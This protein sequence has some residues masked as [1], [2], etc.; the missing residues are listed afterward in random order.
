MSDIFDPLHQ[1]H[2]QLFLR[3]VLGGLLVLAG[4][5]KLVDRE[6]SR[7]AVSD[8]EVLPEAIERPFSALLPWIE[9][10]LGMLLLVGLGMTAAAALAAPLF[11]SFAI[12]IGINMARGR[13]FDCH[14]FGS[15]HNDQ[16]GWSA[17]LRAT[18]LSVAA[19]VVALGTS[20]FGSL[21]AA[22][23]GSSADL[24]SATEVLPI[25]FVAAVVFDVLI[26]L[27]EAATFR[28]I[29]SQ[30]ER[31]MITGVGQ[32]NGHHHADEARSAT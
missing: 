17:L 26:L 23:F 15:V 1:P 24:P 30:R 32:S 20:R 16:I 5:T 18:L 21:E 10:S 25:V 4:V 12:A 19:L 31:T 14:C 28:A 6:G 9:L 3:F 11:A 2:V 7:T 8:Y 13:H 29:F 27:P 22:L